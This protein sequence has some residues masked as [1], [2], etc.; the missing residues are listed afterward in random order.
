MRLDLFSA[1]A[2]QEKV[3]WVMKQ[4]MMTLIL[5]GF[6]TTTSFSAPPVPQ[7][8]SVEA[9]ASFGDA[10][11]FYGALSPYGEWL[12]LDAGFYA[13]RPTHVQY[14]WRPY[15]HGRWAWTDYGWY[16]IS[17]E[18]F[19]WAT[20]HYGRWYLDDSYG[21]VWIPDHTWGPAWV[22]WRYN[23]DYLGWAP[24][25]PYA[26]FS[27]N[28]GI[29]FTTHW[30]AP[31]HYWNFVRY[32]YMTSPYIFQEVVPLEYGRRLIATTRFAGRYEY[33]NGRVIN[34]GV[35][36]EFVERRGGY[37]RIDRLDVRDSR[38]VGERLVRDRNT[39]RI[40][41]YRP[42]QSGNTRSH[43]RIEAR[44][45]DRG[46]TLD[47]QKVERGHR[48]DSQNIESR[49]VARDRRVPTPETRTPQ[50]RVQQ[51]ATTRPREEGVQR[52]QTE[53]RIETPQ[54]PSTERKEIERRKEDRF[55]F[56]SKDQVVRPK[57]NE[58][59]SLP[60]IKPRQENRRE[61][62]APRTRNEVSRPAP[63]VRK[64]SPRGSEQGRREGSKRRG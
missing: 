64:E 56:P 19:G 37:T 29:R 30:F 59:R 31:Y 46:T 13:W 11:D 57:S 32:R 1:V 62:T 4:L 40:E 18:P 28:I 45:A 22:E 61:V 26:S 52:R 2:E 12:E 16:W 8:P 36:R 51:P 55:P 9:S 24:L 33:E 48:D 14:G 25:P 41:V 34:R 15:L 60:V 44:R 58:Q 38:D 42:D 23:D 7:D 17:N 39:N 5:V 10:D 21:W 43:E 35:E 6:S 50:G 3:R 47:L 63:T 54:V 53:R 27:L 20:F 49:D